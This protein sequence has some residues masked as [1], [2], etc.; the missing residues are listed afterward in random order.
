MKRMPWGG[1]FLLIE[2]CALA[3]ALLVYN[4]ARA[5]LQLSPKAP[6]VGEPIQVLIPAPCVELGARPGAVNSGNSDPGCRVVRAG[7]VTQWAGTLAVSAT[8]WP[9]GSPMGIPVNRLLPCRA[10]QDT[11]PCYWRLQP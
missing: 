4:T 9:P 11:D 10:A 5:G 3:L 7:V 8:Y 1:W 6:A 2:V